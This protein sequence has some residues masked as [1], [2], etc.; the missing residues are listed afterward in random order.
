MKNI[1]ETVVN[2]SVASGSALVN[3]KSIWE[4][5]VNYS[6]ASGS[7]LANVKSIW[8]TVVDYSVA[9]GLCTGQCEEYLGDCG[10]LFS[11]WALHWSM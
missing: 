4:T 11:V 6:V 9:S 1:W 7:A 10:T 2:Y 8:E 5:V 3:V